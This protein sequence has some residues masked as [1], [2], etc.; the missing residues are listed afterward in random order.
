ME[1]GRVYRININHYLYIEIIYNGSEV[2]LFSSGNTEPGSIT[3]DQMG[4]RVQLLQWEYPFLSFDINDKKMIDF[5]RFVPTIMYRNMQ[6]MIDGTSKSPSVRRVLLENERRYL[7]AVKT[8]IQASKNTVELHT[9]FKEVLGGEEFL[10]LI[11]DQIGLDDYFVFDADDHLIDRC[12]LKK[13]DPLKIICEEGQ[14][15]YTKGDI[16]SNPHLYNLLVSDLSITPSD[17]VDFGMLSRISHRRD[18]LIEYASFYRTLDMCQ[19]VAD[20]GKDGWRK[21]IADIRSNNRRELYVEF[22]RRSLET[23]KK[24]GVKYVEFSFSTGDTIRKMIDQIGSFEQDGISFRFLYS[25]HRTKNLD[26]YTGGKNALD[27]ILPD[28]IEQGYVTGFDLM[29]MEQPITRSDYRVSKDGSGSLHDKLKVVLEILTRYPDKFLTLRLH[30]G[31]IYYEPGKGVEND[32]PLKTLEILDLLVNELNEERKA[33]GE[34]PLTVPPPE[35]RIGHG[36]HF[37]GTKKYLELLRKYKVIVEINASSNFTLGNIT[38]LDDIPYR[39]Y[40]ENKIPL[41]ISTDGG[42]FYLTTPLDEIKIAEIFGGREV[43]EWVSQTNK[44]VLSSVRRK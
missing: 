8:G 5:K 40:F 41:V 22:L 35:I 39:W 16:L 28:L 20:E 38:R 27:T 19:L 44:E 1:P 23:L 21:E 36:L 10:N 15:C 13:G 24:Q 33:R 12:R 14:K 9:H 34:K 37:K 32:N 43:A 3:I 31:E 17:Q 7:E 4:S 26:L 2:L 30:A 18:A 29:G 42:G 25:L 11:L 6:M